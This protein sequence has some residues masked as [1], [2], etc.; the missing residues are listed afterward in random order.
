MEAYRD[1]KKE[2]I[3]KND[4]LFYHDINLRISGEW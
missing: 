4:R 2:R 1:K 3:E